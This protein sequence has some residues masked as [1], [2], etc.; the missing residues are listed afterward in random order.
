[1]S[2]LLEKPNVT[3]LQEFKR[4]YQ[5][6]LRGMSDDELA[7]EWTSYRRRYSPLRSELAQRRIAARDLHT[8]RLSHLIGNQRMREVVAKLSKEMERA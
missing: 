8:G 3:D 2:C 6:H 4:E 1:L 7:A 5:E